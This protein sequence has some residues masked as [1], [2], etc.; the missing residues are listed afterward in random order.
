MIEY[1]INL[2]SSDTFK[3]VKKASAKMQAIIDD[4]ESK[5]VA[6]DNATIE[7]REAQEHSI[8]EVAIMRL[9]IEEEENLQQ[10]IDGKIARIG[11][12]KENI[13]KFTE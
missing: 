11:R 4:F 8:K 2:F 9:E 10:E 6:L 3:R 13:K 1:L 7:L 12:I 5:I